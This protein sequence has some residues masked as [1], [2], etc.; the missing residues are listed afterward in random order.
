VL[1]I[2][3]IMNK[4]MLISYYTAILAFLKNGLLRKNSFLEKG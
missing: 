3:A 1:R 4:I 2:M